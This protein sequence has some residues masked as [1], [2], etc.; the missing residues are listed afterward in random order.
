[1]AVGHTLPGWTSTV[2][3]VAGVGAVQL[4]CLGILGEYVGRMYAHLQARPTYFVAYDSLAPGPVVGEAG[5]GNQP[6]GA[7]DTD[8]L[9][10]Y[11]RA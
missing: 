8:A 2:V 9:D 1:M 5:T 6:F 4:L 7:L 10:V 3:A 11:L